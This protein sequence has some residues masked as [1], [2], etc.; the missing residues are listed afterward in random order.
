VYDIQAEVQGRTRAG[1]EFERRPSVSMLVTAAA[2]TDGDGLPDHYEDREGTDKNVDDSGVDLDGDEL[3]SLDEYYLGTRPAVADTEADGFPDDVEL[4]QNT[5]PLSPDNLPGVL[6]VSPVDGGPR[7]LPETNLD[8]Y[9]D[10]SMKSDTLDDASIVVIGSLSGRHTGTVTYDPDTMVAT[11]D[12]DVDF[13]PLED[14]TATVTS[15]VRSDAGQ[16]LL[17]DYQWSFHIGQPLQTPA[18]DPPRVLGS[19]PVNGGP[20][21][22]PDTDIVIDFDTSIDVLTLDETTVLIEGVTS[23]PHNG[24]YTYNASTR[25]L[26]IDPFDDFALGEDVTVLVTTDV[27]GLNGLPLASEYRFTFHVI[28]EA[29]MD[30]DL[31]APVVLASSPVDGGPRVDPTSDIEIVFSIQV[32]KDTL[33]SPNVIVEGTASGVHTFEYVYDSPT[34]TATLR[35]DLD[36]VGDEDVTVTVTDGVLGNDGQPL[37]GE[38]AFTFHVRPDDLP[39]TDS[40]EILATSPVSGGPMVSLGTDIEIYFNTPMDPDSFT[41]DTVLVAGGTSGAHNVDMQYDSSAMRLTID[42]DVDFANEEQVTV[43]LTTEVTDDDGDPLAAEF[44]YT[45][46]TIPGTVSSTTVPGQT[47]DGETTWTAAGSPYLV[48]GNITIADTGTLTI[49]PGVVVKFNSGRLVQ[50]DGLLDV[51]ATAD[52]RVVFTSYRDDQYGGDSNADE[53]GTISGS[54]QAATRWSTP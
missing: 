5:N 26:S 14:V 36:F 51:Q 9:F 31:P 30:V 32:D 44:G 7:L 29:V 6:G 11:F 33:V 18:A 45:F 17:S 28:P 37:A 24:V 22:S 40:P 43:T 53:I 15:S 34:R 3:T 52:Q 16:Q 13:L 25:S 1:F 8:I 50:V 46:N 39:E 21:V 12:P 23:G 47:I 20:R 41:A 49:E 2:D 48:T 42:P 4:K 19:S 35:P 54:E 38:Y 27:Y 10:R